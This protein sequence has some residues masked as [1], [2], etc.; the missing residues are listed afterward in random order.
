MPFITPGGGS[1]YYSSEAV[2]LLKSCEGAIDGARHWLECGRLDAAQ[3]HAGH[4]INLGHG[5]IEAASWCAAFAACVESQAIIGAA[6]E[7]ELEACRHDLKQAGQAT[8]EAKLLLLD[9]VGLAGEITRA[10]KQAEVAAV[11]DA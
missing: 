11:C 8:A 2:E 5:A 4:A 9:L 3:D 7:M 1:A 6:D 10:V